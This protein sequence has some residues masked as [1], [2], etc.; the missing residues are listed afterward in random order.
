MTPIGR[1]DSRPCGSGRKSKRCCVDKAA[2]LQLA[3]TSAERRS[4]LEGLFR[5]AR[6]AELDEA[7]AVASAAFWA[8]WMDRRTEDELREAMRLGQS[9]AAYIEWFVFDFHLA[10]GRTVVGEFLA[11]ERRSLRSGEV[12]YLERVRLA[13]LRPY[14]I[15]R[16]GPEE[17][18]DLVDLWR[19][20]RLQG[21]ERLGTR[22]LAQWDLLAA[23]VMLGPAGVPV[24]DSLPYLYPA[25]VREGILKRLRGAHRSFRRVVPSG[26]LTAFFKMRGMLFHHRWPAHVA[27]RR[28]PKLVT[29]EGDEFVPARVVFDVEDPRAVES[30]LSA[31]PGLK[32][33]DDGSSVW[34]EVP[35]TVRARLPRGSAGAVRLMSVRHEPGEKF[36][37]SLGI[38]ALGDG[39]LVFEATSRSRAERGRAGIEALTGTAVA[40]RATR[41]ESVEQALKRPR[42]RAPGP[43]E[44]PAEVEAAVMAEFSERH[45]RR[46][47]DEPLPALGGRAPHQAVGLKSARPE[48]I[49]LLKA[50]RTWPSE[51]GGRA[52]P[53]TTSAG[54]G[55]SWGWTGRIET[56]PFCDLP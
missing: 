8:D 25:M 19:G 34:L 51:T 27:I 41:Y 53:P 13:H 36:R 52:D 5:F 7:H 6:R 1:N 20:D 38:F 4:A 23:R 37:R 50:M 49:S 26:N 31:R 24:L 56:A 43:S 44:I 21:R 29:P 10:T 17:G 45:H 15:A 35:T 12:R 28:P 33:R 3:F 22:Q 32:R 18:L 11:R 42:A 48:L 2:S 40:S 16:V 9:E 46:W 30:A 55:G 47:L 14:E 54:Y 39:R